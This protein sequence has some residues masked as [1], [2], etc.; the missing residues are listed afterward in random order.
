MN[1]FFTMEVAREMEGN[2]NYR[3]RADLLERVFRPIL[4]ERRI[5]I[6]FSLLGTPRIE[7]G[8]TESQLR[9]IVYYVKEGTK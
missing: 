6:D 1:C 7:A 3:P 9:N 5:H 4:E 2:I 8:S